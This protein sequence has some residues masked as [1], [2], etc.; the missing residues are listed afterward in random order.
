[1]VS[2]SSSLMEE[3]VVVGGSEIAGNGTYGVVVVMEVMVIVLYHHHSHL[4]S[5]LPVVIVIAVVSQW[6]SPYVSHCHCHPHSGMDMLPLLPLLPLLTIPHHYSCSSLLSCHVHCCPSPSF[7][8][9]LCLLSSLVVVV[10]I[11]LWHWPSAYIAEVFFRLAWTRHHNVIMALAI[12][13]SSSHVIII[14][15]HAAVLLATLV[16]V[17]CCHC[18]RGGC[19]DAPS[20]S[21]SSSSC[22]GLA[23]CPVVSHELSSH[24]RWTHVVI[25]MVVQLVNTIVQIVKQKETYLYH[26]TTFPIYRL[27]LHR[28]RH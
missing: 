20:M 15:C 5:V 12:C 24:A 6:H 28:Y 25:V 19:M 18:L 2:L 23:M 1:M 21:L 16:A 27:C 4:I 10:I 9:M 13:I 11:M 22:L 26:Q 8:V 17:P 14:L 3:G 7:I